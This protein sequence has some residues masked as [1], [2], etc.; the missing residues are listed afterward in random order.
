MLDLH[1]QNPAR[2]AVPACQTERV[3]ELE[4]IVVVAKVEH[5]SSMAPRLGEDR[6]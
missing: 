1:H 6:V 3:S 4:N 5:V 2:I